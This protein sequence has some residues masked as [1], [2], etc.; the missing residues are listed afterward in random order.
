MR[1]IVMTLLLLACLPA[2]GNGSASILDFQLRSLQ[3]PEV[4][5]LTMYEG[6][7]VVLVFF[8]PE[9]NWCAKQVRAINSLREQ[10]DFEALAVGVGGSRVELRKE[11]RHLRPAFPAYQASPELIEELGGVVATPFT[12][13]GN[14]NGEFLNWGRGFLPEKELQKLMRSSG[15]TGC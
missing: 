14:P 11:L 8:Q 2:M 6:K 5:S 4:H 9:C 3:E 10:C 7:P 13:L 15:Q 1:S 12:L